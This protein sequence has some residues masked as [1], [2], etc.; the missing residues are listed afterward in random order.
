MVQ[1]EEKRWIG[2]LEAEVPIYDTNLNNGNLEKI[3][4]LKSSYMK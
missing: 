4:N 2:W 1:K 3:I